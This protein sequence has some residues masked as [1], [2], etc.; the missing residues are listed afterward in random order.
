M[1]MKKNIKDVENYFSKIASS[2]NKNSNSFPWNFLRRY[3]R[4]KI[5]SIIKKKKYR[6]VLELGSGSGYYTKMFFKFSR[7]IYAVDLSA[8][9]LNKI[10]SPKVYKIVG[11][12]EKINF[13]RKFDLI[14][15]FGV[16]EFNK[17]YNN[18]LKNIYNH[19][20]NTTEI[21]LMIPYENLFCTIYKKF[22]SLNKIKLNIMNENKLN[23]IVKRWFKVKDEKKLLPFSKIYSCQKKI[24]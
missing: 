19:S 4:K 23:N 22:H 2:Y 14:L 21:Y 24:N 12:A 10:K 16:F 20:N 7:K 1:H 18:I 9:M 6:T 15:C 17:N 8:E 3:E 11:N 5:F 13:K